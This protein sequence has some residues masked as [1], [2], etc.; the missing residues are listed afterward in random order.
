MKKIMTTILGTAAFSLIA[1]ASFAAIPFL[2][3]SPNDV[4]IHSTDISGK[5]KNAHIEFFAGKGDAQ[6]CNDLVS[7]AKE[8]FPIPNVVYLYGDKLAQE[9]GLDFSC[10][11]EVYST[12]GG[13]NSQK[14]TYALHNDGNIYDSANPPTATVK[15]DK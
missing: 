15:I 4:T 14:I 13:N 11:Q 6:S 9:V 1:G 5:A 10:V 2:S 3:N 7:L 12:A 8:N